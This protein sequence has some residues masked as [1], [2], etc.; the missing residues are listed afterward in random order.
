MGG[1]KMV[2]IE[3]CDILPKDVTI[4]AFKKIAIG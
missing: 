2:K 1:A 3:H 4:K